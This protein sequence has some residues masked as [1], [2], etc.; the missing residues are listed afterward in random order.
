MKKWIDSLD[1]EA[2]RSL[3]GALLVEEV[4]GSAKSLEPFDKI[5]WKLCWD[6]MRPLEE[7]SPC[8]VRIVDWMRDEWWGERVLGVS[9]L[10]PRSGRGLAWE[11]RESELRILPSRVQSGGEA[12][13]EFRELADEEFSALWSRIRAQAECDEISRTMEPSEPSRPALRL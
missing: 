11:R 1:E 3:R 13:A 12:S 8:L 5:K 2:L 9:C 4:D 6:E 7:G 10:H